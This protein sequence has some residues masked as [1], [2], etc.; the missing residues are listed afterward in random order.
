M[1]VTDINKV[2]HI[3]TNREFYQSASACRIIYIMEWSGEKYLKNSIY[4][5]S[6]IDIYFKHGIQVSW[7]ETAPIFEK[8]KIRPSN[9][10]WKPPA[11]SLVLQWLIYII[12]YNICIITHHILSKTEG[13]RNH[14][15][16]VPCLIDEKTKVKKVNDSLY[17]AESLPD[18]GSTTPETLYEE[19]SPRSSLCIQTLSHVTC[20][21]KVTDK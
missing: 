5:P 19:S 16:H 9:R 10:F 11:S 17:W 8:A 21:P 7:N 1:C 12:A 20:L 13:M 14:L 18:Q 15:L 2:E 4:E 6:E 3:Y